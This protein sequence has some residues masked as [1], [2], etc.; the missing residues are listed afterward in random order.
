M[1]LRINNE[2]DISCRKKYLFTLNF[3][4]HSTV[5]FKNISERLTFLK[6]SLIISFFIV[7]ENA[8]NRVTK[9]DQINNG[10]GQMGY[11]RP[12]KST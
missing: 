5:Q 10:C 3:R 11:A 2:V 4:N 1:A 12:D 7:I 9:K 8:R 6:K